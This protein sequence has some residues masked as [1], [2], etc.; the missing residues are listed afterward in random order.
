MYRYARA[1][2]RTKSGTQ[3]ASVFSSSGKGSRLW[4]FRYELLD[5][6]RGIAALTVVAEHLEV[7]TAGQFAVIL[8]FVISGYCIAAS[9]ESCRRKT[10]STRAF[11]LRRWR[12][13]YPPYFFA[14][15]FYIATRL[16]NIALGGHDD[17]SRSLI[18]WAQNLTLTQWMSL[19]FHPVADAPRNPTLLVTAFWSL[20]Y[21]EQFY[22]IMALALLLSIRERISVIGVTLALT[23]VGLVWNFRFPGGWITG[24]FI[25]YWVHFS[26]GVILFYVLCVFPS[27]TLRVTFPLA[28]GFLCVY[29]ML[30]VL[31]WKP[32]FGVQRR[33]YV[34]L[35]IAS[36]FTLFL[37]YARPLSAWISRQPAWRPI[38]GLGAISY[39]LYLVHQF[40][41]RFAESIVHYGAP[42]MWA[43]TQT[44][45]MMAI[46]VAIGTAFWYFCE[47]PFLNRG[48]P[49]VEP[50]STAQEAASAL[51][52]V[53]TSA[54]TPQGSTT[55]STSGF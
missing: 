49:A 6:L 10:L 41:L 12:R 9:A 23:V 35:A 30:H 38:A 52:A 53:A 33:A 11:M 3:V 27:R 1:V 29:C 18:V 5:G 14:I 17:L 15:L 2:D 34:E 43:W 16:L 44:T 39:S 55:S 19:P 37:F 54:S 20:N 28:V 24:F 45:A 26:L 32:A 50:E 21:E 7:T 13:I 47:R 22:L 36:G 48:M 8:F 25:E 46:L 31:P 40:N 4:P 42:R 51:R